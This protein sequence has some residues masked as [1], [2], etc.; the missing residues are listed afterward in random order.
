MEA[1]DKPSL[2]SI[3]GVPAQIPETTESTKPIILD[4]PEL[5]EPAESHA[6]TPGQTAISNLKQMIANRKAG[7]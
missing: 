6:T 7:K 2:I 4:A 5:P 3:Y 1:A